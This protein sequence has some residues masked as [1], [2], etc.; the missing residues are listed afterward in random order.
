[1]K[2]IQLIAGHGAG[3]PGATAVHGGMTYQEAAETRTL[4]EKL[5]LAL[6]NFDAA[7]RVYPTAQNAYRD[8]KFGDLALAGDFALEVHFNAFSPDGGDGRRKGTEVLLAPNAVPFAAAAAKKLSAAVAETLGVP[9][10]GV[11][12]Q[13][14]AVLSAAGKKGIPAVLL[15]VCFLDDADDWAAYQPRR[16]AVAA[17][18][19][20]TLAD[21]LGCA[22]KVT[23]SPWAKADCAW[24]AERGLFRGD[25][26]SF[27]WHAPVTREELA[28]VLHRMN[29]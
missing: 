24:A 23:C 28:A 11:K 5:A 14:L 21:L 19:A 10:R 12:T 4:V 25:G 15:E 8:V 2:T 18:V 27:R 1:M 9:D 6:E 17:A 26:G 20:Q 16:D 29:P 3:D 7:A 22:P 13:N